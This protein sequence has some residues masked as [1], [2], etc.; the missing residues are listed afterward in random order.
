MSLGQ[1][2]AV[3]VR[4]PPAEFQQMQ[5]DLCVKSLMES[6]AT[7]QRKAWTD[8]RRG[9]IQEIARLERLV[10]GL[11][12]ADRP[13]VRS[14]SEIRERIEYLE[15]KK[16]AYICPLD[17]DFTKQVETVC[18]RFQAEREALYWALGERA[19]LFTPGGMFEYYRKATA[20]GVA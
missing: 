1:Q 13:S 4:Q 2:Q 14:E 7:L 19:P 17:M 5:K 3:A 8:N 20:G 6:V 11:P 15:T 9:I 10:M 16:A 18:E 12:V